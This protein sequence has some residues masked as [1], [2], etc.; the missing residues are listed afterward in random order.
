MKTVINGYLHK[1]YQKELKWE[2]KIISTRFG[3]Q[4]GK[5]IEI[6]IPSITKYKRIKGEFGYICPVKVKIT[7]EDL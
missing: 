7:I 2:R 5:V 6:N 4:K 1:H 3:K